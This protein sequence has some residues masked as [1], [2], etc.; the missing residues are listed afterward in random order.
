MWTLHPP[1]TSSDTA[2][3]L[4]GIESTLK[5]RL[6]FFGSFFSL[7][8]RDLE[9]CICTL[10]GVLSDVFGSWTSAMLQSASFPNIETDAA[11]S[12]YAVVLFKFCG[13]AQP[14]GSS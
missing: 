6:H 4:C 10:D 5:A 9:V 11:Q 14:G 13:L 12:R 1:S 3:R 2:T 8:V 7:S